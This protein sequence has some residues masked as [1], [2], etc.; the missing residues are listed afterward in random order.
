MPEAS[1]V[2]LSV[3]LQRKLTSDH[4]DQWLAEDALGVRWWALIAIFITCAVVWWKLLDK[5]RLKEDRKSVV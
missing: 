1:A 2:P 4:I 3:D 5:R